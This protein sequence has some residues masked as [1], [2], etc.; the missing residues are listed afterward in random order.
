MRNINEIDLDKLKNEFHD[1]D[2]HPTEPGPSDKYLYSANY[3]NI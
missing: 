2:F 3:E 1:V